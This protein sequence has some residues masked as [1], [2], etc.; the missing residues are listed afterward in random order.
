MINEA[1]VFSALGDPTRLK[2]IRRLSGANFFT[3][4]MVSSD[5]GLTRQGVRRHIQ[6]LVNAD[7]VSLKPSGRDVLVRLNPVTL[8]KA[9]KII[10]KLEQQWDQRLNA[11]KNFVEGIN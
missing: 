4:N 2:I 11:L 8:E 6:V 7:L 9:K 1:V 3:I 5:L 10:I